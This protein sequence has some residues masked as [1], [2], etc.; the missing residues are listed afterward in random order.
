M[1]TLREVTL[2][3]EPELVEGVLI[4]GLWL[5]QQEKA[6]DLIRN[7]EAWC[8]SRRAQAEEE[9]NQIMEQARLDSQEKMANLL[10][11]IESHFLARSE[12]LFFAWQEEKQKEDDELIERA[13]ALVEAVFVSMFEQL[14][15]DDKLSAVFRQ[16]VKAT[17]KSSHA[18]LFFNPEHEAILSEWMNDHPQLL[19]NLKPDPSQPENELI[20][21]TAAGELSLSWEGFKK[22]IL[23]RVMK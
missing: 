18:T 12:S 23:S 16:V 11:E 19:W 15:D 1:I 10:T 5:E 21:M 9:V 6:N 14:P 13:R 4:T 22:H 17:D 20:L 8:D 2:D 7:T 3:F